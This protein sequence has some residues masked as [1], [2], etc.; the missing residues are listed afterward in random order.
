MF[1]LQS[2][3]LFL[4][5]FQFTPRY[6]G[7]GAVPP[8]WLGWPLVTAHHKAA[9]GGQSQKNS[10]QSGLSCGNNWGTPKTQSPKRILWGNEHPEWSFQSGLSCGICNQETHE[11]LWGC[12]ASTFTRM[13]PR[14]SA[15][16]QRH[17][18]CL[19]RCMETFQCHTFFVK[20]Q[21]CNLFYAKWG[22]VL[23]QLHESARLHFVVPTERR[24]CIKKESRVFC[25]EKKTCKKTCRLFFVIVFA[26]YNLVS[27]WINFICSAF[28]RLLWFGSQLHWVGD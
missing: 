14:V 19:F 26:N 28:I 15:S 6:F 12:M 20:K 7:G 2:I 18:G 23:E 8:Q 17:A 10:F 4:L 3:N 13:S 25:R 9:T 27:W 5:C 22:M 21:A 11:A 24:G 16:S 1:I